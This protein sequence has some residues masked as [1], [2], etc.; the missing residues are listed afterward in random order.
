M[1]T[2]SRTLW[3]AALLVA[4]AAC[5]SDATAPATSGAPSLARGE[6]VGGTP[7]FNKAGTD[8]TRVG[9][10]LVVNFK[11]TGLAAG[12]VQ[13][14]KLTATGTATFLCI[15]GG[16][17]NPSATN[18]RT[19]S[20]DVVA[21]GTFP[22]DRNGNVTGSLTLLAPGPGDFSCPG[23]QTLSGAMDVSFTNVVLTDQTSGATR[24]FAGT[25]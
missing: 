20:P 7:Q 14:I 15:N 24:S 17:K 12:S 4:T 9:D 8:L 6:A 1:R 22:S 25:F 19:V 23:G 21:I 13:T 18:K 10:N 16:D 3:S 2:T 5:S 11:E